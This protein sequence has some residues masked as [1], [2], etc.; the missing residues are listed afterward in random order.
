[1]GYSDFWDTQICLSRQETSWLEVATRA[2]QVSVELVYAQHKMCRR[3]KLRILEGHFR[4]AKEIRKMASDSRHPVQWGILCKPVLCWI[5]P[6]SKGPK[7]SHTSQLNSSG[8]ATKAHLATLPCHLVA[9][10]SELGISA[11]SLSLQVSC[12]GTLQWMALHTG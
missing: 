11:L 12:T 6:T 3:N 9:A 4:T 1:M 8:K 5:R 2:G 10:A 7:S